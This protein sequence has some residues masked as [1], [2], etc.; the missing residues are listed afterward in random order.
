MLLNR[1]SKGNKMI[2]WYRKKATVIVSIGKLVKR[3][4]VGVSLNIQVKFCVSIL[5]FIYY[6]Y[7]LYTSIFNKI[8]Y[9]LNDNQKWLPLF[10]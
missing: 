3:R 9:C 8:I 5:F 10:D 1:V 4:T 7:C 2:N 6:R